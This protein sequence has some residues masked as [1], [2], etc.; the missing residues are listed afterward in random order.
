MKLSHDQEK[1]W[2]Q[3]ATGIAQGLPEIAL[4]GPAGTGKSFLTTALVEALRKHDYPV[5]LT[6]TTNK[7]ARVLADMGGDEA[8]TIHSLLGLQPEADADL[9]RVVLRQKNKPKVRPNSIIV[10]DEASMVQEDLLWRIRAAADKHQSTILYVGDAYQLPPVFESEA[11]VFRLVEHQCHLTTIHRQALENPIIYVANGFRTALDTGEFPTISEQGKGIHVLSNEAFD[12]KILECFD[13]SKDCRVLTWTNKAARGYNDLVRNHLYDRPA[14]PVLQGEILVVN[15]AV[16]R[17]RKLIFGTDE[18]IQVVDV[19][20]DTIDTIDGYAVTAKSQTAVD[21]VFVPHNWAD[22]AQMMTGL[23]KA[24]NALER[25]KKSKMKQGVPVPKSLEEDR[26]RAWRHFFKA[27]NMFA[28]VRPPFASTVHK[29]QGST[30]ETV[31][32]DLDDI[33]RNNKDHEIARLVY[34]ALTRAS[35]TVYVKGSLP[36]RLYKGVAA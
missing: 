31:F 15:S 20:P 29:G 5:H 18:T 33:G 6:A 7:A 13:T 25:E 8:G 1:A 30:Y 21:T 16:E 32:V 12:S 17:D 35:E 3:I 26:R 10:V 2:N 36:A 4:S 9:G 27:Q 11:P 22:A 28:D 24:A 34:V 19:A 14:K 23:A